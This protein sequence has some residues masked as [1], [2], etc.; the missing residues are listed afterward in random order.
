MFTFHEIDSLRREIATVDGQ[1]WI[2]VVLEDRE[3]GVADAAAELKDGLGVRICQL[4]KFGEQPVPI[5][6][7]SVLKERKI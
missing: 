1:L 5:F 6:E 3:D 4:G 2:G 7:E